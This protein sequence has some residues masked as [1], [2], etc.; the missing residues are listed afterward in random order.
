MILLMKLALVQALVLELEKARERIAE[1][2]VI[3][4]Y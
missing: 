1:L 2:I 4:G 3:F